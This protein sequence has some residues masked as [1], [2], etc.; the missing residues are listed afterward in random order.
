MLFKKNIY[1][2][3][4]CPLISLINARLFISSVQAQT[5]GSFTAFAA[6]N[7]KIS[8]SIIVIIINLKINLK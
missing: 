3:P 5:L 7:K 8:L 6:Y 1:T 4:V 2:A